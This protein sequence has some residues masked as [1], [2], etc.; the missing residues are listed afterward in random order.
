VC[1]W[2]RSLRGSGPEVRECGVPGDLGAFWGKHSAVREN[3][4][5]GSLLTGEVEMV[6]RGLDAESWSG[7]L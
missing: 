5:N 6:L 3:W 2:F 4:F 1:R 7:A